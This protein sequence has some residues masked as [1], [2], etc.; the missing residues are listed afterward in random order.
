[1]HDF[2]YCTL[3]GDVCVTSKADYISANVPAGD[4]YIPTG[5]L[6]LPSGFEINSLR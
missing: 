1:V 5:G 2:A 4:I 3:P 6:A